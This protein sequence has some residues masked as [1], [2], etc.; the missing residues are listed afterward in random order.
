[1][2]IHRVST[3]WL[4][5]FLQSKSTK[6]MFFQK[7]RQ[8]TQLQNPHGPN[9]FVAAKR[10][11]AD[12][13]CFL[14][15]GWVIENVKNDSE[16]S[17]HLQLGGGFFNMFYFY[18]DPW[19]DDPISQLHIFQMGWFFPNQLVRHCWALILQERCTRCSK[20]DDRRCAHNQGCNLAMTM[21]ITVGQKT[22]SSPNGMGLH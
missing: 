9:G 17:M 7:S 5:C 21:A 10:W 18:P 6:N 3:P 8:W 15:T 4:V 2:F 13:A 20:D 19:G 11:Q 1:M 22:G 12:V 16:H 14:Q